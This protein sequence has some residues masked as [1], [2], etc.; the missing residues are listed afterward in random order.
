MDLLL[1]EDFDVTLDDRNDLAVTDGRRELEQMIA[2]AVTAYFHRE[3]GSISRV[4]AANN[5]EV[6]ARRVADQYDDIEQVQSINAET[7]GDHIDVTIQYELRED[8]TF[9]IEE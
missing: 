1:N 2:M 6:E 3:I 4:N 7:M 8:I 5:I 9:S